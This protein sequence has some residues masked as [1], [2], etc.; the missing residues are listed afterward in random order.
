MKLPQ[1]NFGFAVLSVVATMVGIGLI[2]VSAERRSPQTQNGTGVPGLVKNLAAAGAMIYIAVA[3]YF[4][5]VALF[6]GRGRR[7]ERSATQQLSGLFTFVLF[8]VL[9][10]FLVAKFRRVG[11]ESLPGFLR[12]KPPADLT[13]SFPKTTNSQPVTWGYLLGFALVAMMIGLALFFNVRNRR[14]PVVPL[15]VA[16]RRTLVAVSLEELLSDLDRELDPRRA[17]LLAEQGM[18][19]ALAAHGLPRAT[20]ETAQ[21]HVQR[22]ATELSLSNTAARTLTMLYGQAHFSANEISFSDRESAIAALQSVRDELR[23][24]PSMNA[25]IR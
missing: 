23:S 3:S 8:V 21:E 11:P 1:K 24:K 15:A 22:I 12:P 7:N 17:V 5:V 13:P 18:E 2:M 16:D 20:T 14:S 6:S 10:S 4:I 19:V 9:A 25:E